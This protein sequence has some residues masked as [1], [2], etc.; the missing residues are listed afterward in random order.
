MA[1]SRSRAPRSSAGTRRDG[2][3][4]TQ[5]FGTDGP[6]AYEASLAEEDGRLVWRMRSARDRFTGSFS[7]DGNTITGRWERLDEEEKWQPWMEIT[8]TKDTN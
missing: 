5:Y 4:V 7:E 1:R 8:L 3:Y 6:N 2:V